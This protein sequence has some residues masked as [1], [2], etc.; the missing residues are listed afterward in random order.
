MTEVSI[1]DKKH[2]KAEHFVIVIL[3]L[4]LLYFPVFSF[5]GA[6]VIRIWDES[7]LAINA[8]E[9]ADSGNPLITTY[10]GVPETWNTKPTLMVAAQAICIKLFGINE[11]AIRLPSAVAAFLT[12]IV[13]Y[14]FLFRM[15]KS[16]W[17]SAI[18]VLF[19]VTSAG[20]VSFHGIRTG[21]YDS[22]LT[23]FTTCYCLSIYLYLEN[24]KTNYFYCFIAF[25]GLATLTKGIAGL[26]LVPGIITYILINRKFFYFLTWRHTYIGIFIFIMMA[27]MYYGIREIYQPGYLKAVSYNE[28]TGRFLENIEGHKEPFMYYLNNIAESRY[29]HYYF[30]LI[31]GIFS[32]LFIIDVKY[33]R[34]SGFCFIII[35]VFLLIISFSTSKMAHYD[36]PMYPLAALICGIFIFHIIKLIS[37]LHFNN[38]LF[39]INIIPLLVSLLLF[40]SPYSEIIEAWVTPTEQD[41]EK[42]FYSNSYTLRKIAQ[43]NSGLKHLKIHHEGYNAHIEFYRHLLKENGVSSEYLH[44]NKITNNDVIVTSDESILNSIP[45]EFVAE[46]VASNVFTS[47]IRLIKT[48]SYADI[49]V[50]HTIVSFTNF[51]YT[52]CNPWNCSFVHDT[53]GNKLAVSFAADFESGFDCPDFSQHISSYRSLSGANSIFVTPN[54]LFSASLKCNSDLLSGYNLLEVEGM[55]YTENFHSAID[56]VYRVKNDN[57]VLTDSNKKLFSEPLNTKTWNRFRKYFIIND[58]GLKNTEHLIYFYNPNGETAYFDDIRITY[59]NASME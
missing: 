55:M 1:L 32:N 12:C 38:Q 35:S 37:A 20:Y 27:G 40:Y 31:L 57:T 58:P 23:L 33:R 21:D 48:I 30:I 51:C 25:L 15:Y 46:R 13:L 11:F 26:F 4:I 56:V 43:H 50:A 8:I 5:L 49:T 39:S 29:N 6:P 19:L 42:Y 24:Y 54:H 16:A 59:L 52:T 7:R 53:T 28:I 18:S 2:H 47:V 17:I 10:Q 44:L 9:M 3:L 34:L 36:L 45:G 41:H 22:M 14:L